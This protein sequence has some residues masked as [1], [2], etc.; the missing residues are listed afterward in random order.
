MYGGSRKVSAGSS[1][2]AGVQCC[3]RQLCSA[4]SSWVC[5]HSQWACG[6]CVTQV[7]DLHVLLRD[8][9][10]FFEGLG[11]EEI[12]RRGGQED[13]PLR[14]VKTIL[15]ELCKLKGHDIYRYTEQLPMPS[16]TAAGSGS[17]SLIFSYIDLNVSTLPQQR[18]YTGPSTAGMQQRLY[19]GML[20]VCS[21]YST[22]GR[23]C[24]PHLLCWWCVGRCVC[25]S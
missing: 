11:V 15:H 21:V 3:Q 6:A 17:K 24:V 4:L 2:M 7:I 13:K 22:R 1:C 9:H 20:S 19:T 16:G 5:I 8:I 14:M 10:Y 23:R 12:R 25:Q 18:I